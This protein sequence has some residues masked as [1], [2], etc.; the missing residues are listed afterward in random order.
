MEEAT[1]G[2]GTTIGELLTGD[3]KIPVVGWCPPGRAPEKITCLRIMYLEK[4]GYGVPKLGFVSYNLV[5]SGKH[6][7]CCKFGI[8]WSC[9]V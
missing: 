1:L 3:T 6:T 7:A 4:L 8:C 2:P 9:N 5:D